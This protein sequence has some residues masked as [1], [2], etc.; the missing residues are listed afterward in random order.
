MKIKSHPPVCLLSTAW[1]KLSLRRQAQ[2]TQIWSVRKENG[3]HSSSLTLLER[4][5]V[6]WICSILYMIR[7]CIIQYTFHTVYTLRCDCGTK[8]K[9]SNPISHCGNMQ[10]H[11][12]KQSRSIVL[13][14]TLPLVKLPAV[15]V[16]TSF[17]QVQ[18]KAQHSESYF[19]K[20][21][22]VLVCRST[23]FRVLI[24]WLLLLTH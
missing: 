3:K 23:H 6:A 2:G 13:K 8:V 12:L 4:N 18:V 14:Q 15:E 19:S 21:T 7:L 17:T 10:E 22:Y 16:F 9:R 5:V 24:L 11:K 1:G 20:S